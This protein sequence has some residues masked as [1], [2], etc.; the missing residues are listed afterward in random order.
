M[1]KDK[2]GCMMMKNK[3]LS[4]P[5]YANEILFP[6]IQNDLKDLCCDNFGNYFLQTFLD[7]ITF[8]NLNK[9]LDLISK[10]FI[11]I[12]TSSQGTRVIQKII[13]KISFTPILI[14]KFIYILNSKDF[15]LICKSQY[16]NH[17]IQKIILTFHSSEYTNFIYNYIFKNFFD[18][19]NSKHGV[20]IV[21]KCVSEGN[22][23]QREKLYKL[24]FDNL[25]D[26]IKNEYGNYL[27][28]FILSN[29]REIQQIFQEIL[30]I[31]IKIEQNLIDLCMSK[32]S[33][34]VI[35]KCIE[36]S[37][38]IIRKH[39]LDFLFNNHSNKIIDIF[40]NK[41]GFYVLLKASKTLNGIYK[42][43]LIIAFNNN[44][45]NLKQILSFNLKKCKR[46]IK[47]VSNNKELEEI[48]AIIEKNMN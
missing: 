27:I 28:Q 10:D 26:I 30:P 8:D 23:I 33:A 5:S 7:I 6:Q 16:G 38:N 14:N 41:F 40:F 11:E 37:D 39:I 45:N 3:I 36:S 44:I 19:T 42:N 46:I 21:Q 12:C 2:S 17:I 22:K 24:I 4:D 29:N 47:I 34:N 13:D 32:Y 43:K 9:F 31:I 18:I 20:F 15:G 48:Y 35:E 1:I 25:I